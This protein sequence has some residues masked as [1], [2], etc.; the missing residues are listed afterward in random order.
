MEG[1]K[2]IQGHGQHIHVFGWQIRDIHGR[3]RERRHG[4]ARIMAHPERFDR[5]EN[6][7]AVLEGREDTGATKKSFSCWKVI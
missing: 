4:A 1:S 5:W 7:E 6:L 3:L 2:M